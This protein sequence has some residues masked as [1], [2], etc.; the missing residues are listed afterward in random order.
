MLLLAFVCLFSMSISAQALKEITG[1]V[2]DE[3]GQPIIGASITVKG[4][5][6]GAISDIDGNFTLKV[7]DGSELEVSYIGFVTQ[8]VSAK[9]SP[10]VVTLKEDTS[11]LNEV[12]VTALG[13]K[14]EA[15]ALSYNVQQISADELTTV[16]D[17]SFMNSL[18]GKVAGVEINT[19]SAGVGG[20]VKVVM[21]GAKSLSHDNNALYVIDGIPMPQLS[22][23][24]PSDYFSGQGQ[25]GDGASMVNPDDIESISVLSGSAASALYGMDAANGVVMITT[26]KG[27]TGKPRLTYSNNTSFYLPFVTPEFQNTYG[28]QN[29]SMFSWGSK[30]AE[31]STYNPLDF[32]QTGFNEANSVTFSTGSE[33]NQ[34]FASVGSNIAEGIIPNNGVNRLNFSVRNSSDFMD[35][36]LHLDLSAM[37][38]NVKEKNM[39]SSGQYFNP[40]LPIYLFPAGEDIRK[41]MPFEQYNPERNFKT[42]YWPFGNQGLAMQNPYWVINRDD[43]INSKDRYILSGG[44]SWNFAKGF[45]LAG[46][47]KMDKTNATYEKKYSAG[48]DTMFAGKYGA[49]YIGQEDTRQLYGDAILNMDKYFGDFSVNAN[50]GAS[51]KDVMYN[52]TYVGGQLN[53]MASNSSSDFA[54]GFVLNNINRTSI[55]DD[56]FNQIPGH[57]HQVQ[58]AFATAQIGFKSMMYLD[59]TAR[60]DWDSYLGNTKFREKGFFY[61]SVGLSFILTDMIPGLKSKAVSFIKLRG[62]Y[63]E[64]GHAP[65]PFGPG[66]TYKYVNGSIATST[67]MSN[68]E[69]EPERTKSWEAGLETHFWGNKLKLNVSAYRTETTNQFF[70]PSLSAASGYT[71]VAI[72]GG[73]VENKGIEASLTLNQKIGQVDWSSTVNYTVNRNKIKQ[74]LRPTTLNGQMVSLDALDVLNLGSVKVRLTEGGSIGDL[75]V[76]TLQTDEHGFIKVDYISKQIAGVDPGKYVYAGN[77]APRANLSWRNSFSWKGLNLAALVTARFGGRVV[78]LTQGY[79]DAYGVSTTTAEARDNGGALVNG[80][81]IPAQNYYQ[82]VGPSVGANYVYDATNVRLAE[83]SLGYNVPVTKWVPWI[84]DMN[85]SL[86]G[87]NLFM[88]YC[89]APFDPEL[90]ATTGTFYSGIDY[91]MQPSLRNVGFSV[92]FTFG[93][94]ENKP[95]REVSYSAPDTRYIEKVVEKPVVTEVI[96]DNLVQTTFVVTFPVNSYQIENPSELD[97]IGKGAT[98]EIVAYASP[99]GNADA[100]HILSQ[101]RADAVA[102]YLKARGV[103]V[104]RTIAKGANSNHSNR[105]AIVTVK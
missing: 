37:Y 39:I 74:L 86:V 93:S 54:H 6:V 75:Y 102:N 43:F 15:K 94:N 105:I 38:T 72:N 50:L 1:Q 98:V 31:P 90:S 30:L 7:A 11:S 4:Q 92:K 88:F 18:A 95:K 28:N 3:S 79:M 104:L 56:W 24:Q 51:I 20:G 73:L 97:G 103:N 76:T 59:A 81:L 70:T 55:S 78:S 96:K 34:T 45:S 41:F 69:L 85:L 33:H 57:H 13:I 71:S 82:T 83:V 47:A 52:Y 14:K 19:S 29:G 23:T 60:N 10:V 2:V 26:K 44:L 27:Q 25:S 9:K 58:S 35:D 65:E 32:F 67:Q 84:Q 87:R 5:T 80:A 16:K 53:T 17:A 77:T 48:G 40:L 42:M 21:R 8:T 99:E 12:V 101:N 66:G 36:K 91:F 64:V 61:P 22:T 62:S 100:N 49:Y 68:A 63:S 89:K 46:R